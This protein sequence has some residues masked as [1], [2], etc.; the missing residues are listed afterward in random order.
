[1]DTQQR[2]GGNY[3]I[4]GMIALVVFVMMMQLLGSGDPPVRRII[5]V[6]NSSRICRTGKWQR[7]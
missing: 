4:I 5:P 2:N 6:E 3:F 7:W 1:M